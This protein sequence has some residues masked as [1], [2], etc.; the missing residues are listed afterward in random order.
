MFK[1]LFSQRIKNG[2]QQKHKTNFM[3]AV[4]KLIEYTLPQRQPE[5]KPL[6][7]QTL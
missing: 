3:F 7:R 2:R 4:Y 6:P 5:Y 1:L